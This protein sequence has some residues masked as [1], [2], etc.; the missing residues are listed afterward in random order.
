MTDMFASHRRRC[1]SR[2]AGF[3]LIELLV[4]IAIIG[5]LVALLLPAVQ[6]AREAARRAQC[7]NNLKQ[8]GLA[9]HNYHD[10]ANRF[11]PESIWAF[12]PIGS[13]TK[14][15]RNYS[16]IVMLLPYVDQAPLYNSINFSLPIWGQVDTTGQ[17]IVS[18]QLPVLTCPSD[19]GLGSAPQGMGWTNYSGAEGYDWWPRG[20][21]SLGGMFTLNY[22]TMMSQIVDGT[23]NTIAVG[24]TCTAGYSGGGFQTTGHG[25]LNAGSANAFFRPAL[26]SPPYSDSQGSSGSTLR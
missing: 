1:A 15:P 13:T 4:V 5:V 11:P 25:K 14:Q 19:P 16:W 23:S 6:Q 26:V 21:D 7:K 12:T 8:V 20:N 24:E 9:L 2:R 3:T 18:R 10:V 22:S 17:T